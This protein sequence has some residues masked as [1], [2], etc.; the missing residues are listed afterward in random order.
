MFVTLDVDECFRDTCEHAFNDDPKIAFKHEEELAKRG[1]AWKNA[2]VQTETKSK[3]DAVN[4]AHGELV[5]M[6]DADCRLGFLDKGT[7]E[8]I[9]NQ[10]FTTRSPSTV[11]RSNLWRLADGF[12]YCGTFLLKPDS[13]ELGSPENCLIVRPS[14]SASLAPPPPLPPHHVA[15][16]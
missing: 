3:G 16:P 11:V 13:P 14:V 8:P 6:M 5:L 1:E 9:W 7:Q 12:G 10:T 15:R 4:T 2:K